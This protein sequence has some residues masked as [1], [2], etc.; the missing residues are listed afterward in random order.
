MKTDKKK[1]LLELPGTVYIE[2]TNYCNLRCK[3]CP[4]GHNMIKQKGYMSFDL[5]RK[6]IKD[7]KSVKG[8]LPKVALHMNGEPLLHKR[9][10][11]M[12]AY[13][14]KKGLYAFF[15][16]NG[17]LLNREKGRKL[18]DAGISKISFSFEGEDPK[19]YEQYRV[20]ANY[21]KVKNNIQ[22]FLKIKGH[23]DVIVEVLKFSKNNQNLSI[24]EEF[25]KHF[26]GAEFRSFYASNWHGS[27][28]TPELDEKDICLKK[29]ELC[30]D[31]KRVFAIS[32]D[33]KVHSCCIDYN[34]E[35]ITGDVNN[36]SLIEIWQGKKRI[37]LLELMIKG[38]HKKIP[39]C[40]NCKAPYTVKTKVRNKESKERRVT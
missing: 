23:T 7:I 37:E 21:E 36:Q 35:L 32:W 24:S 1:G 4:H 40:K 12:V 6:I 14:S 27:L 19:K 2:P 3:M 22:E 5:Y 26:V 11:D 13:A 30:G 20:N 9:I 39:L 8:Y 17:M 29:P 28:D 31:M 25:K 15:H 18:K 33:G 16:T 38:K 34:S 10:I